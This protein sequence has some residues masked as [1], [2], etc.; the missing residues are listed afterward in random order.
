[1]VSSKSISEPA[2]EPLIEVEVVYALPDQQG[3]FVVQLAA[4]ASVADAVLRSGILQRYPQLLAEP[5]PWQHRV[6]VFGQQCEISRI[7]KHGDRVEIYRPL[8]IEPMQARR[9]RAAASTASGRPSQ[10]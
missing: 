10:S 7:L 8:Q 5:L 6:G 3:L 4:G 1:M 2:T 9:L